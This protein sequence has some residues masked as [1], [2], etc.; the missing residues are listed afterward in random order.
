MPY[1]CIRVLHGSITLLLNNIEMEIKI[2]PIKKKIV[3]KYDIEKESKK[4]RD[5]I[6]SLADSLPN[7][8]LE[9]LPSLKNKKD[10]G[11]QS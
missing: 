8:L 7:Y 4:L 2:D 6:Q 9:I 11:S 5:Q 3:I 10:K 1:L